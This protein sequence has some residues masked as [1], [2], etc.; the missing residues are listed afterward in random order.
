MGVDGDGLALVVGADALERGDDAVLYFAQGF[1]AGEA[2]AAGED[3]H[4]LPFGALAELFEVAAAP[5]AVVD[6]EDA[7]V[8]G[9]GEVEGVGEGLG[10]L[11]AAQEGAGIDGADRLLFEALGD[12]LGLLYALVVEGDG[13]GSAGEGAAFGPLVFAVA[14]EE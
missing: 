14:D 12:L 1:A 2:E 7:G 3:L 4:E 10:G 9:D 5:V 11:E 8:D 13:W 6:L